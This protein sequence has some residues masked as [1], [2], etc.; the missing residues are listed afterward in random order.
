MSMLFRA[1]CN[2]V[3]RGTRPC[4]Q[5][6]LQG[7]SIIRGDSR[8]LQLRTSR[9]HGRPGDAYVTRLRASVHRRHRGGRS[10][11][12]SSCH[13]SYRGAVLLPS[14]PTASLCDWV[15]LLRSSTGPF[16]DYFMR[17]VLQGILL[18]YRRLQGSHHLG[19][20]SR[21]FTGAAV[22]AVTAD[23]LFHSRLRAPAQCAY[24][25]PLRSIRAYGRRH[26]R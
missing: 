16:T 17:N 10:N 11:V 14:R 20:Y 5:G 2:F 25:L 23:W 12:R 3:G 1:F 9:A 22:M 21:C 6:W 7:M 15:R 13:G 4:L 18:G 24:T 19:I 26:S 8:S